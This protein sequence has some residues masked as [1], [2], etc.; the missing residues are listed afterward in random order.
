LV[1][2]RARGGNGPLSILRTIKRANQKPKQMKVEFYN[3]WNWWGVICFTPM[4][5]ID[6]DDKA[7]RIAWII[8]QF[9]IYKNK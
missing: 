4:A 8:W 2:T 7:I 9:E 1:T 5:S 3:T 6:F